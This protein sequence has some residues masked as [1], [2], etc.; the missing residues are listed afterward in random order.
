[1]KQTAVEH[2]INELTIKTIFAAELFSKLSAP[3]QNQIIN[4]IISLLSDKE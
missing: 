2:E 1:M 3:A 4:L